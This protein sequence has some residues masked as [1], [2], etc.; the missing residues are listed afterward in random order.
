MVSALGPRFG[1]E[2]SS[3]EA[4]DFLGVQSAIKA[5]ETFLAPKDGSDGS[6]AADEEKSLI[7]PRDDRSGAGGPGG[8][9]SVV[10]HRPHVGSI[11]KDPTSVALMMEILVVWRLERPVRAVQKRRRML[12]ATSEVKKTF[13]LR[14]DRFCCTRTPRKHPSVS[15]RGSPR[16]ELALRSIRGLLHFRGTSLCSVL[17]CFPCCCN[18][19]R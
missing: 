4:V 10:E 9:L 19:K 12:S 2:G 16:W 7:V 5:A 17:C 8:E 11:E 18:A 14:T 1:E 6:T 13:V 15:V 3:S